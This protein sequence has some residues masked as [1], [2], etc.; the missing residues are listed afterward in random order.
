MDRSCGVG[1]LYK[2]AM[3]DSISTTD[4]TPTPDDTRVC[5]DCHKTFVFA[6]QQLFDSLGFTIPMRCPLCRG[7]HKSQRRAQREAEAVKAPWQ[8]R[9]RR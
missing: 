6:E 1:L 8:H 2:S 9:E 3:T 4:D 5:T 7:K